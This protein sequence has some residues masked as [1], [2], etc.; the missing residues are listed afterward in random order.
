MNIE[1]LD[2]RVFK[3]SKIDFLLITSSHRNT[4][5]AFGYYYRKNDTEKGSTRAIKV[6]VT[7]IPI[8][9]KVPCNL[10]RSFLGFR[11]H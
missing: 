9:I 1:N 8:K 4:Q 2:V 10:H 3:F 5:V 6:R 11:H 7:R